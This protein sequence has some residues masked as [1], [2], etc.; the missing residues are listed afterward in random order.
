M[1]WVAESGAGR[2][3]GWEVSRAECRLCRRRR[4]R[5]KVVDRR[6]GAD[7][8]YSRSCDG[9]AKTLFSILCF[10]IIQPIRPVYSQ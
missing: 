6:P 8:C 2:V 9:N 1:R 7:K 10:G 4:L 5:M 3:F